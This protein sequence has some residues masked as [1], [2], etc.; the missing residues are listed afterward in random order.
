MSSTFVKL[1]TGG[2]ETWKS[3]VTTF[4]NLPLVGNINGD[5]RATLDT[6]I[7]YIWSGTSWNA[8]SGGGGGS[9]TVTSVSMTVPSFL[10]ISGSPITSAGTLAVT[11]ATEAANLV[12]AGPTSGG[13]AIPTFRALVSS[14]LPPISFPLLAPD[15]TALAPSYAFSSGNKGL[16]GFSTNSLGFAT[17]GLTAGNI[18]ANQSWTFEGTIIS[19]S[20]IQLKTTTVSTN[21]IIL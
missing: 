7:L 12:F 4:A 18:D 14:D 3:A 5:I 13:S 9:G 1:G 10:N 15:G 20:S 8:I 2:A 6:E 19:K 11:L 21:Y 17:N 16:Y